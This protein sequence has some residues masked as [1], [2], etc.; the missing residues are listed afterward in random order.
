MKIKNLKRLGV[1]LARSGARR[2]IGGGEPF[3][4][5]VGMTLDNDDV[6]LA[7]KWMC[8]PERWHD[9]AVVRE[10]EKAFAAWNGSRFAFALSAGRKA[11]SAC[12]YGLGLGPGDEV[13][14]PGYTCIVVQNAFDFAG[15]GTIHCDVELDTFGPDA[16]SVAACITPRTKAILIHH[17]Y[18]LV[19]RDYE[20]LLEIA[21]RHGLK[22]IE[23]CAHSSGA[24]FRGKRV[25]TYGD[26]AFYSAEWSKSFTAIT[27]GI[28]VTNKE[29]VA[30]RMDA[31]VQNCAW[32]HPA[33]VG[34][35]L[36]TVVLAHL[37]KERPPK[38]WMPPLTRFKYGYEETVST[39]QAE[40]DG[41]MPGDYF[42]RMS[43]AAADLALNQIRKIDA[44]NAARRKTVNHWQ[45]WCDNAGYRKPMILSESEPVFLRYPVLV[46]PQRKQDTS[47]AMREIGINLGVWFLT[48]LHPSRRP[49]KSCPNAD[50]AVQQCVNFP[51]ILPVSWTFHSY[52]K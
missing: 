27:G 25:G 13:I 3:V 10:F 11:L 38:W 32:P 34:K 37:R 44:Y 51:C 36:R 47:W 43:A 41:K 35:Q 23:D 19:C 22:T 31:F 18:G 29:D 6:E 45:N 33:V 42:T 21:R 15:V 40:I 14:I 46:E 39:T 8:S 26:V 12:I 48:N 5:F 20:K 52:A 50:R 9:Q 28:A 49:V 24:M 16:E 30:E 1:E 2:V 4:P 17:I 7:K